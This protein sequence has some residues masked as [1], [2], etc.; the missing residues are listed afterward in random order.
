MES[1]TYIKNVKV[2]PKKLR[3]IASV[4]KK[5]S[6]KQAVEQLYYT[7]KKAAK[8]LYK[9]I[10]SSITNA[11][12][13]LKTAD[14][15]LEF[16]SLIIEEGQKLKRFRPGS[17]GSAKPFVRRYSH[18]KIVLKAKKS[19]V[20]VEKVKALPAPEEKVEE[21]PKAVKAKSKVATKAK[22]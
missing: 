20:P 17:R 2:T 1:H 19:A 8:I 6:P 9:A 12:Q 18:I 10:Q 14:D 5:S 16:Q 11:K 7:P 13:K 3:M 22:K 15:S 21:K 4:V